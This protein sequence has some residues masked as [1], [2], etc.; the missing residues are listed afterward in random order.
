[1]FADVAQLVHGFEIA[2]APFAL[3]LGAGPQNT[4]RLLVR[5]QPVFCFE[6]TV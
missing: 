1:L 6:Q 4:G 3:P 2:M 5:E